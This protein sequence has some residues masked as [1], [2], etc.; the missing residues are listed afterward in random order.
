MC[1][2]AKVLRID[3]LVCMGSA[4]KQEKMSNLQGDG[5]GLSA[6]D[7]TNVASY[8]LQSILQSLRLVKVWLCGLS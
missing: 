8:A 7:A 5:E 2:S 6:Q 3:V 4:R 1:G